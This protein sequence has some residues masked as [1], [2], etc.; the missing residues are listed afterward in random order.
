MVK[1]IAIGLICGGSS[2]EHEVSLA[3]CRNVLEAIDLSKYDPVP[4]FID[5]K[6]H[7]KLLDPKSFLQI[8]T[9]T[10]LQNGL[11]S[12]SRELYSALQPFH[13][14]LDGTLDV[15]FPL[16]HGPIGEDGALQGMLKLFGMPFVGASVLGSAIG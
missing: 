12:E 5:K 10:L 13:K 16:I 11:P 7:W 8:S 4:I 6:G 9:L 1:K 2:C 3:S 14:L 15:V